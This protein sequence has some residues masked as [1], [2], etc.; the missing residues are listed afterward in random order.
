MMQG[1]I[2]LQEKVFEAFRGPTDS[3]RG[4]IHINFERA[5]L[6]VKHSA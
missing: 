1:H 6:K 2:S 5:V 3:L 4:I